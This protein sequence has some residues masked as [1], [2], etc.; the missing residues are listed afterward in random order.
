MVKKTK[1]S[2]EKKEEIKNKAA[3]LVAD[4]DVLDNKKGDKLEKATQEKVGNWLEEQVNGLTIE[5]ERLEN[6]LTKK[7]DDYN[8]LYDSFQ[9]VKA[10]SPATDDEIKANIKRIF[11]E[12]EDNYLGRNQVRTR[13]LKADIKILLDKFLRYFP[14]LMKSPVK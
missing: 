6:E 12:L 14:F 13:Y 10:N 9:A 3:A 7:T 4:L 1:I 8:K 2:A 11:K 5:N